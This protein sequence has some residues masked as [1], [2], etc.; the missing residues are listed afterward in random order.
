MKK[1]LAVILTFV[2]LIT[3]FTCVSAIYQNFYANSGFVIEL[4]G[5]TTDETSVII[6]DTHYVPLRSVFEKMGA[7]VFYR[8]EDRLILALSRDGDMIYHNVGSNVVTVNDEKKVFENPSVLENDETYLPVDMISA[9]FCPD[10]ISYDT[11][12]LNIQKQ[13]SDTDY[14]KVIKDVLDVSGNSNFYPEKFQRYISYHVK[15][16][17]YGTEEVVFRVNLGLDYPFYENTKTIEQPYELLVL[18][19]KYNVLPSGFKQYNLVNMGRE[20]TVNDG[21]EYKLAGVAYESYVK[22]Y[23]AAKKTVF[24]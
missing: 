24:R 10:K 6:N 19:N 20:Y 22:M 21:K 5:E 4:N 3:S 11:Q 15:M 16:P 2:V 12:K 7:T 14:H 9:A 1:R 8:S 18:V 13:F 17:K 23:D